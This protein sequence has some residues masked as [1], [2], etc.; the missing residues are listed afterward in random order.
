MIRRTP[1]VTRTDTLRPYTTLFLSV[2]VRLSIVADAPK[3]LE[4][5]PEQ[6]Q[7]HKAMVAQALKLFGAQHYDHYDLMFSLSGKMSGNGLE[8]RSEANTSELQS[9][10]RI[11]YSVF[12]LNT[13]RYPEHNTE[14]HPY[15]P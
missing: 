2:P 11:S 8:H 5:K 4:T 6:V 3:Y 1:R 12:C 9:L 7:Q 15:I 13:K 14:H 10:M